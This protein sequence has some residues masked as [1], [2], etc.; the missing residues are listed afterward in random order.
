MKPISTS[1][2]CSRIFRAAA[3]EPLIAW[4]AI[5]T[6]TSGSAASP[7]SCETTVSTSV[8]KLSGKVTVFTRPG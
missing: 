4:P 1:G 2:R 8:L 6:F 7:T 5:T 3:T